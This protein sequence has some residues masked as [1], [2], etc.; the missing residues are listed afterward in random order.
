MKACI[1]KPIMWNTNNY[2]SPSGFKSSGGFSK[3][4]GY[5]HEEWNNNQNWIWRNYKVF[6][7]EFRPKILEYSKSGDLCL[8]MIASH[9]KNQY[10]IGIATNVYHND[11]EEMMLITKE[12]NI[13]D[14]HKQIWEQQTVRNR[15]NNNKEKF[16]KHWKEHYKWI[17]WKCSNEHYKWFSEP[18]LLN[19]K[20]ITG[21]E[22]FISM[23]GSY[24][25]VL[26]QT[27]LE[28][29][30]KEIKDSPAIIEWLTNGEFDNDLVK[31][32]LKIISN[33]KLRK[34][35]SKSKKNATSKKSFSYWIEGCRNVEPLHAK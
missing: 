19:A 11:D 9:N 27:I 6:H 3:D 29:T 25:A 14:N 2:E 21:K 34:K 17:K 12:L 13:F 23:H 22:K 32:N 16:L 1:I 31:G 30:N 28:I 20:K 4:Y 10:A 7:T 33:K 15:F 18:I 26:S 5:G 35:Y 8:L 24:Q